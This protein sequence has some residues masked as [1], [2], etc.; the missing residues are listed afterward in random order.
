ML[1]LLTSKAKAEPFDNLSSDTYDKDNHWAQY[2]SMN[3]THNCEE[4]YVRGGV[5]C[6]TYDFSQSVCCNHSEYDQSG[7]PSD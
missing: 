3:A 5:N 4:C 6:V 2:Y 1:A 7:N